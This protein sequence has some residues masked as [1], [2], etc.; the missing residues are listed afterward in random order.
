MA[1][2]TGLLARELFL[3]IGD[4]GGPGKRL[5]LGVAVRGHT[6]DRVAFIP[7]LHRDSECLHHAVRL[8]TAQRHTFHDS[9]HGCPHRRPQ[10]IPAAGPSRNIGIVA[11]LTLLV[12][13][14]APPGERRK[15]VDELSRGAWPRRIGRTL[16][17]DVLWG[18]S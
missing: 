7:L 4:V 17:V 6:A 15:T 1:L 10:L 13:D 16:R 12:A 5:P 2:F 3:V 14:T 18:G 9:G 11:G 8:S